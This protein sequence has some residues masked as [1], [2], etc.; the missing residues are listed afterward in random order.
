[1]ISWRAGPASIRQGPRHAVGAAGLRR[2]SIPLPEA[3]TCI[4][5]WRLP[6]AR[7]AEAGW[8][9]P[10]RAALVAEPYHAML[11][12]AYELLKEGKY[13]EAKPYAEQ[14][15]QLAPNLFAAHQ[16]WDGSG[17]DRRC[18][19]GH[20]LAGDGP[21]L[22]PDS[23]RCVLAGP[24]LCQAGRA[25]EAARERRSRQ[26]DKARARPSAP[27]VGGETDERPR[28][29][30][31]RAPPGR[32]SLLVQCARSAFASRR[33]RSLALIARY[34][35]RSATASGTRLCRPRSWP[36]GSTG[37]GLAGSSSR[38]SSARLGSR[39]LPAFRHMIAARLELRAA[40]KL[41]RGEH[42]VGGLLHA[43]VQLA[44]R[45]QRQERVRFSPA[46]ARSRAGIGLRAFQPSSSGTRTRL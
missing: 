24:R 43:A 40:R 4:R 3:P 37:S 22:A 35:S 39:F 8:R 34:F 26:L 29:T 17:P 46:P 12:I 44:D 25:D 28:R 33:S 31:A 18:R 36:G 20:R 30:D 15:A 45:G 38:P 19:Q 6:R 7:P 16:R 13:D 21:R 14:A 2:A 23:P 42:A 9:V 11:Q 1:M 41:G 27:I 5:V 32:A 10:P